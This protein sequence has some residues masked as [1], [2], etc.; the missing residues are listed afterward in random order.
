MIE[1]K[2]KDKVSS[3]MGDLGVDLEGMGKGIEGGIGK[4]LGGSGIY[5]YILV[6][7]GK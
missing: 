7:F 5:T 1:D 6:F 3:T 4:D 2:L